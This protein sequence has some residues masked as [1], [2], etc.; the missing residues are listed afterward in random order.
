MDCSSAGEW[1][2]WIAAGAGLLGTLA[3]G[4]ISYFS[5]WAHFRRQQATERNRFR[6]EKLEAA[7]E[8][9]IATQRYYD[10]RTAWAQTLLVSQKYANPPED[11]DHDANLR[12]AVFSYFH[13]DLKEHYGK[14]LG[15]WI[16]LNELFESAEREYKADETQRQKLRE[17]FDEAT[18]AAA[19]ASFQFERAAQDLAQKL[20]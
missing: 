5:A 17:R 9:Y 14:V 3:G 6:L 18:S 10:K 20:L 2:P 16:A 12:L 15:S 13:G 7:Y 4:A 19:I 8:D 11:T 1:A